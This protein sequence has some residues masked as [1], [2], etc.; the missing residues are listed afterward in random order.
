MERTDEEDWFRARW[1]DETRYLAAK[2]I[3]VG[4]VLEDKKRQGSGVAGGNWKQLRYATLQRKDTLTQN[5]YMIAC[6]AKG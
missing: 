5:D 2:D 6:L 3:M 4:F 1:Y